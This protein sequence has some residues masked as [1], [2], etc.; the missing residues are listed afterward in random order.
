MMT[1]RDPEVI[2]EEIFFTKLFLNKV[3]GK[4]K[5]CQFDYDGRTT[6]SPRVKGSS[7]NFAS[8]IEQIN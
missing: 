7:P 1:S 8:N 6:V 4:S 3:K 2:W 5:Q